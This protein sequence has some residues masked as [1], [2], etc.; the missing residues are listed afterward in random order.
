MRTTVD[1]LG[2]NKSE[3]VSTDSWL[4]LLSDPREKKEEIDSFSDI[5]GGAWSFIFVFSILRKRADFPRA[6]EPTCI[7]V[8]RL[9][10]NVY[11]RNGPVDIA[12]VC[13]PLDFSPSCCLSRWRV[14][15]FGKCFNECQ[16][17]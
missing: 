3:S 9:G 7:P 2:L 16:S 8:F 12:W 17:N 4:L 11:L 14:L 13:T 1:G 5:C 15:L 10:Y 6:R